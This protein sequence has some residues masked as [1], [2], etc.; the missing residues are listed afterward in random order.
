MKVGLYL[1][2]QISDR[3][4]QTVDSMHVHACEP[5]VSNV[6]E[7][8]AWPKPVGVNISFGAIQIN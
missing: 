1:W 2:D 8:R 4:W 3:D 6:L 5:Q 7:Q